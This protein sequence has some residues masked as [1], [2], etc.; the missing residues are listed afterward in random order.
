MKR[1]EVSGPSLAYYFLPFLLG[2][3]PFSP[4]LQLSLLGCYMQSALTNSIYTKMSCQAFIKNISCSIPVI[5]PQTTANKSPS[6]KRGIKTLCRSLW[7]VG[8]WSLKF[9]WWHKGHH[10]VWK[11]T[12][13][14]EFWLLN[15]HMSFEVGVLHI[16]SW[17]HKEV[18]ASK[19]YL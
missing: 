16:T 10:M 3:L 15:S 7:E 8:F 13:M 19:A 14:G 12:V 1:M 17:H 9:A 11:V 18:M 6:L 5:P 4:A 2:F